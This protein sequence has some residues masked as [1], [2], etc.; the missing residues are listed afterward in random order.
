MT[1]RAFFA[2][3]PRTP[4]NGFLLRKGLATP[5]SV[6]VWWPTVVMISGASASESDMSGSGIAS[7]LPPWEMNLVILQQHLFQRSALGLAIAHVCTNGRE[8]VLDV[9]LEAPGGLLMGDLDD[10]LL[11][12]ALRVGEDVA[13]SVR[14][15]Q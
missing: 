10:E 1:P 14:H 13:P 9:V 8:D 6:R 12:H 7:P 5:I 4:Y 11:L 15:N 2:C 3:S